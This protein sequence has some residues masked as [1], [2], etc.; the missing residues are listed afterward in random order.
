[1]KIGWHPE[2]NV[3]AEVESTNGVPVRLTEERWSHIVEYHR[4]L[5][6]FQ[7]EVLLT[8]AEPDKVYFSP[9]GLEPNFAAV[10]AFSRLVEL[11]LAS[12]LA[13]HYKEFSKYNGFILTAFV[14]SD[15]RIYKRFR[16]WQ[17]IR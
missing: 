13:V 10:K 6:N 16:R 5:Q 7:P 2:P 9:M 8:V 3:I 15:K 11:G 12:N 4:E 14:M 1:M 17:R